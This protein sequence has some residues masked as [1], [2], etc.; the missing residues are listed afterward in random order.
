MNEIADINAN[1]TNNTDPKWLLN[2]FKQPT[3]DISKINRNNL[4]SWILVGPRT[5]SLQGE[6][7]YCDTVVLE[8]LLRLSAEQTDDFTREEILDCRKRSNPYEAVSKAFFVNR[9]STKF[10]NLDAMFKFSRP[11]SVKPIKSKP[12]AKPIKPSKP[13]K[14]NKNFKDVKKPVRNIEADDNDEEML[15]FVDINGGPGGFVDYLLWRRGWEA[16]GIGI[17][18]KGG[19]GTNYNFGRFAS[20]YDSFDTYMGTDRDGDIMK[21]K[22][23]QSFCRYVNRYNGNGVRLAVADGAVDYPMPSSLKELASKQ[24]IVCHFQIALSTLQPGGMLV[25]KLF[26]T[27]TSF[28][29]G[30]IYLMYQCFERITIVKPAGSR[31]INSER[32]LVGISMKG[33]AIVVSKHLEGISKSMLAMKDSET[34]II[35]LVSHDVLTADKSFFNYIY[36]SNNDISQ[37][38][39]AAMRE[40]RPYR[41]DKDLVHPLQPAYRLR[42]LKLWNLPAE[43]DQSP[44]KNCAE[45]FKEEFGI[46]HPH[47]ASRER[48]AAS[49]LSDTIGRLEDEWWFIPF[50]L[51]D[52]DADPHCTWFLSQ[53]GANVYVWR[54]GVWIPNDDTAAHLIL[55]PKTLVFAELVIEYVRDKHEQIIQSTA[56]HIIDGHMLGSFDLRDMTYAERHRQCQRFAKAINCVGTVYKNRAGKFC[57][58]VE[59]RC[60][61]R[62]PIDDLMKAIVEWKG[63]LDNSGKVMSD[64][65][66]IEV[67]AKTYSLGGVIFIE[68]K[69]PI[70]EQMWWTWA[71][72]ADVALEATKSSVGAGSLTA[73]Y[74]RKIFG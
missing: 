27:F 23:V 72:K 26:N 34:D 7:K 49:N 39:M 10:A 40:M 8:E 44:L 60:K 6:D 54:D 38:Q 50:A 52:S 47:D 43:I 17:T 9:A 53:G 35:E 3:V 69:A 61:E 62:R 13:T 31:P 41:D 68:N 65:G 18:L 57:K 64:V 33:D 36:A 24:L 4:V 48:L 20:N 16:R 14:S 56:L 29:V 11:Q 12:P 59:I 58:K 15:T 19:T 70:G 71:G 21:A 37:E 73:F 46:V 42:C 25:A 32:Y 55:P 45:Y 74:F 1:L 2:P 28:T 67:P 30:L 63:G 22:N 5:V 51:Q 66:R